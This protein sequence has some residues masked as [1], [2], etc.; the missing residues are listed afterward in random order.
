M[1]TTR[2]YGYSLAEARQNLYENIRV[3]AARDE[4]KG[5]YFK[6]N[7]LLCPKIFLSM[8]MKEAEY[9]ILLLKCLVDRSLD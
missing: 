3:V 2:Y 6:I 1:T 8:S 4:G 7:D 9:W 5:L